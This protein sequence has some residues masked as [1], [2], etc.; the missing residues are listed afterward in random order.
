MAYFDKFLSH[1]HS[2]LEGKAHQVIGNNIINMT[3]KLKFWRG[4]Q[5]PELTIF[6]QKL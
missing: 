3:K 1:A 5:W 2:D 6:V 4:A